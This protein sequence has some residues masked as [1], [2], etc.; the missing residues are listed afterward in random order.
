MTDTLYMA[1]K[2]LLQKKKKEKKITKKIAVPLTESR[3][4][5]HNNYSATSATLYLLI[6]KDI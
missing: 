6:R 3:N 4:M 5:L 2:Q 1:D